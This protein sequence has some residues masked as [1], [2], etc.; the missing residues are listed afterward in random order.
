MMN[1]GAQN[2][3]QNCA[4]LREG[5]RVLILH[6]PAGLTYYDA[7][8][9][10]GIADCARE[11]GVEARIEEVPFEASVHGFSKTVRSWMAGADKTIFLARI[12]DQLRFSDLAEGAEA[13]VSYALSEKM[14]ASPFAT[15]HYDAFYELKRCIDVMMAEAEEVEVTCP[16]GT[17]FSG[18]GQRQV[19]EEDVRIRRFP[20][21]VHIPQS[22]TQFS[23]QA[24][25]PGFLVGT[26]SRYYDPYFVEFDGL[27][28]AH[29][30]AGRISGFEGPDESVKAVKAHYDYVAGLFDID[31]DF[32][33]SWHA[34]MHPG[35]A[36]DMPIGDSYDR[37]TGSAFGNPRLLH[38]HTCG[39]Y[40]PGE[41]SWNIV[42]P[43]VTIDGVAVW[44]EGVLHGA[45]VPGG[46]AILDAYPCARA[47]FENPARY[48]GFRQAVRGVPALH[49]CDSSTFCG[50]ARVTLSG[51]DV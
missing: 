21:S 48:I 39:A 2:L 15:A 25:L 17:S 19:V 44:E 26:G 29:F 10:A 22:A 23:G 37:W 47:A 50:S 1:Q 24:A 11:M 40:A 6:E 43:T 5:D 3:L 9:T 49:L 33:H 16:R 45:R 46:A 13:I 36:F 41:I 51:D 32:I 42:D 30:E 12:G 8:I 31:R 27:V 4:R 34:G 38:F 20:I 28:M 7:S 35:C 18:A 14:L